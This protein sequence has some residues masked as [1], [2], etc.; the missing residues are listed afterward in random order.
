MRIDRLRV[1]PRLS[2]ND[3]D[4]LAVA[5]ERLGK[6]KAA[7]IAIAPKMNLKGLTLLDRYRFYANRGTFYSHDW[8]R[9]GAS[10]ANLAELRR[11]EA[12]I[13]KALELNPNAHFGREGVQLEVLR[14]LLAVKSGKANTP[15][16]GEWLSNHL[17]GVEVDKSLAGVIML[18]GS[19]ENPDLVLAIAQFEAFKHRNALCE[20]ALARYR[21][22][23]KGGKVPISPSHAEDALDEIKAFE[24]AVPNH[25]EPSVAARYATLR[26]EA[27]AYRQQKT[28][29]LLGRLHSGLH[30]D[31]SPDFWKGW[32]DPLMPVLPTQT[33]GTH[34]TPSEINFGAVLALASIGAIT[35][36]IRRL[37]RRLG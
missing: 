34:R 25:G 13:A 1:Q 32:N 36:I 9:S 35:L 19:W 12:D 28:A 20:L 21:E 5:Y 6:S 24:V 15:T 10:V 26:S 31:T 11:A 3:Y 29:F 17:P 4:D 37:R 14:W 23:L 7:F 33:P 8:L 27:D 16:L 22:I 18:G 30:P 2:A